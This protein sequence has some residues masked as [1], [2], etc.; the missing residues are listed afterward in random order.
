MIL[1]DKADIHLPN[2]TEEDYYNDTKLT[3]RYSILNFILSNYHFYEITRALE[4]SRIYGG[5]CE[6]YGELNGFGTADDVSV[7]EM[8]RMRVYPAFQAL[9]DDFHNAVYESEDK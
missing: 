6:V 1:N 4:Y 2:K 8:Y 3:T 5:I 9:L 7:S